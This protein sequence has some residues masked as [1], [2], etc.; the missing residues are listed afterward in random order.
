M[1]DP[2]FVRI[3]LAAVLKRDH[4]KGRAEGG[5]LESRLSQETWRQ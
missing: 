5:R 3:V 2:H 4:G 1:E